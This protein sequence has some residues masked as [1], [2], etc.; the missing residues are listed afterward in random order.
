MMGKIQL[1]KISLEDA[2]LLWRMQREAFADLLVR[3]Q[4]T[5]VK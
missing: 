4:D 3:Y 1:A 2:E 5:K